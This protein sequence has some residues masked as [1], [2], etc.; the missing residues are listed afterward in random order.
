MKW[1]KLH[2]E[3]LYDMYCS[4]NIVRVIKLRMKWAGNVARIGERR[5][6]YTVLAG[7]RK[8]NRQTWND[9]A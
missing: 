1:R 3:E 4:P 9:L 8:A 6:A 2:N 7:R 5:S